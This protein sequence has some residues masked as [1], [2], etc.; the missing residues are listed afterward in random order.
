VVSLASARQYRRCARLLFSTDSLNARRKF[1]EFG[2]GG[3]KF[4]DK[5]P[6]P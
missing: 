3:Q 6:L 4:G 2:D 1:S 5:P